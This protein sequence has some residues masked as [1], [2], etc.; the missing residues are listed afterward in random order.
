M[1]TI[2]IAYDRVQ[3]ILLFQKID[4]DIRIIFRLILIGIPA[5]DPELLICF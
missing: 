1:G 4:H 2:A 3:I 5:S